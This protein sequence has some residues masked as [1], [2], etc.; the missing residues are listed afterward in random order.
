MVG[1]ASVDNLTP[2]EAEPE[3]GLDADEYAVTLDSVTL[4][5]LM[6]EVR[7]QDAFEPHAYNR[8]HNRHNR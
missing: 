2:P 8:M 5:R 3:H 7:N 1:T 4:A 6:R